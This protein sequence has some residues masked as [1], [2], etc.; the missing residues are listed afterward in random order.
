[1][2]EKETLIK[3]GEEGSFEK[4]GKSLYWSRLYGYSLGWKI[5]LDL[6]FS[7]EDKLPNCEIC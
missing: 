2:D 7:K 6:K 4:P 5:S 3:E 1:M